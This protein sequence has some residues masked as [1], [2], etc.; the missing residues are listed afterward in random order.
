MADVAQAHYRW[1]PVRA[2]VRDRY[3]SIAHLA[4]YAGPV[5]VIH[6]GRDEVVPA[7]NT[8]RLIASLPRQPQVLEL[9]QSGHNTV[10]DDPAY[11]AALAQ[12]LR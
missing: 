2:L 9:P 10:Q 4:H 7:A 6:A 3:D 12:F 11:G 5:L 8:R 1:L